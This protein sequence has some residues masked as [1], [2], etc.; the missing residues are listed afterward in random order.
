MRTEG[1]SPGWR[2]VTVEEG[3]WFKRQGNMVVYGSLAFY[4]RPCSFIVFLELD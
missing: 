1:C 2:T 3:H 4:H